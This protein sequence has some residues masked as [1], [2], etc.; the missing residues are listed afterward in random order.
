M[1]TIQISYF[2][3]DAEYEALLEKY[4]T[5]AGVQGFL[6][7]MT[8]KAIATEALSIRRDAE[9]KADEESA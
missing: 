3:L 8:D 9:F 2:L 4:K 6:I 5:P 7:R 1:K